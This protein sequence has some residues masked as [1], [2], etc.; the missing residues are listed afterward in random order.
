MTGKRHYLVLVALLVVAPALRADESAAA[1]Q[2]I[3]LIEATAAG[4]ASAARRLLDAGTA[5]DIRDES[6]ATALIYAAAR[7]HDDVARLLLARGADASLQ[8]AQGY[9]AMDYAMERGRHGVVLVLLEHRVARA[10]ATGDTAARLLLASARGDLAAVAAALADKTSADVG[11]AQ[12]YTALAM[13]ARWNHG[14]VVAKLL[15]TGADPNQATHSRYHTVPLMEASR[16]GRVAIAEQLIAA[17]AEV[18][19][20]DRYGDHALNWACYFGHADFVALM[21]RHGADLTRTGQTDDQPLEIALREKHA[22]VVEL[23]R[24]AGAVARAGKDGSAP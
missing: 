24:A 22:A 17:G 21:L 9:D 5:V 18:D 6:A 16:D 12:G 1:V 20:G 14:E 15:A 10:D 11:A 13:A 7:G 23:L 4:D 2:A 8:D 3:P 19:R